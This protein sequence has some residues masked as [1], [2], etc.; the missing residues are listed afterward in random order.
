MN[1]PYM[2]H[3]VALQGDNKIDF[4]NLCIPVLVR[5]RR[6]RTSPHKVEENVKKNS[7]QACSTPLLFD[8][9]LIHI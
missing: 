5:F 6:R 4:I 7:K 9:S 1:I 3:A 2:I 8:L